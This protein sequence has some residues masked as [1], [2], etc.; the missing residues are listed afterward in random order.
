MPL[1]LSLGSCLLVRA[2]LG[3]RVLTVR[4]LSM[5]SLYP[6]GPRVRSYL[7]MQ[8]TSCACRFSLFVLD[9]WA[10]GKGG[11][12]SVNC[13]QLGLV[14]AGSRSCSSARGVSVYSCLVQFD[15]RWGHRER[16]N[17]RERGGRG[18]VGACCQAGYLQSGCA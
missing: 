4:H 9:G 15:R 8:P 11:E 5:R 17:E 1:S 7:L 13:N 2:N 14:S 18:G 16:E 3:S 6:T 10:R 12:G